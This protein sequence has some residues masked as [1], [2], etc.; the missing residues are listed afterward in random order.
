ML[1]LPFDFFCPEAAYSVSSAELHSNVDTSLYKRGRTVDGEKLFLNDVYTD[2]VS[3]TKKTASVYANNVMQAS[4]FVSVTYEGDDA[5]EDEI[6]DFVR[7]NVKIYEIAQSGEKVAL[8]WAS[9]PTSNGFLH[10]FAS[11]YE[12]PPVSRD[13]EFRVPFYFTVPV[14]ASGIHRWVAG[15]DGKYTSEQDPVEVTCH[16]FTVT[17]DNFE[18]AHFGNCI[19]SLKYK[20]SS[21]PEHVRIQRCSWCKQI[22]IEPNMKLERVA[23]PTEYGKYKWVWQLDDYRYTKQIFIM[24]I[25]HLD[26]YQQDETENEIEGR[27]RETTATENSIT[28]AFANGI[29]LCDEYPKYYEANDQV[30]C[31]K[32][33]HPYHLEDNCGNYVKTYL[34]FN[35]NGQW[36]V[37]RTEMII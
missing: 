11:P 17:R 2:A 8:T 1:L 27:D 9:S 31:R 15:Y 36:V 24:S 7:N 28:S 33:T 30:I 32:H 35:D 16:P 5:T 12:S 26:N 10:D 22:D 19:V 29:A 20:D 3:V 6:R 13:Y 25:I 18:F 4:I 34:T 14:G 21:V 23:A 37:Y